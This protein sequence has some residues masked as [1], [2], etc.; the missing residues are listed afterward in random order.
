MK[1][2]ELFFKNIFLRILLIL[3][4]APKSES[5]LNLTAESKIL[6]IRLNRI[7]D[8]LVTT[9]LLSAVKN[10]SECIIH[11]LADKK[12]HFVFQN[13]SDIEKVIVFEKGFSGINKFRKL[14]KS[15]QYDVIVDL[16]DDVST[17]VSFLAALSGIRHRL[18]LKKEN[19]K[20]YTDTIEK[21]N[22]SKFHVIDRLLVLT[23]ILNID[24]ENFDTNVVYQPKTD[25][26]DA[27][28]KYLLS[29]FKNKNYLVGINISAGSDA[30]FWGVER[31]KKVVNSLK[32]Y[33]A[34]LILISAE[35]DL[36]YAEQ[37][38]QNEIPVFCDP[39]FDRFAALVSKLDFLF[40]PDTS[41]IHLASAY[42]V[43]VF[44]LY[45]KYNTD[46]V[47]WYPYKSEYESVITT[48]PN[49]DNLNYEDAERKF[50]IFFEKQFDKKNT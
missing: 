33:N 24:I 8:A 23:K 20:I 35:K 48:E 26:V 41:I 39:D 4:R 37:I 21:L 29:L 40:T 43:P 3:Y 15:E 17:T 45:V 27:V 49:F 13:N 18:A 7:G 28:E 44:G 1:G 31:F 25:S 19:Y 34:S 16:H 36:D 50:L 32:K 6:F 12:N 10:K 42:N 46:D 22:P 38:S 2:I 47:I 14:V 5:K 30:R 9:P 11:V